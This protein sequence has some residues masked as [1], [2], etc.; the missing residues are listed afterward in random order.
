[1]IDYQY[2]Y[3]VG[4]GGIGMSAIARWFHAQSV[5]VVG[6]ELNASALT[7]QLMQE[8]IEIHYQ[9]C[10]DAIPTQIIHHKA[11]SLVIYTPAISADHRIL[12]YLK[13][14]HYTIYKRAAAL[15][16]ISRG[17]H[18]IA[19]AGTHGKT[20]TSAL[21]AH[22][23]YC[24]KKPMV[25][26]IGG[27]VKGYE[28]NILMHGPIT[29]DTIMVVE[30]D[31]FDRSF[32]Q[33][34]PN[35]AIVTS[36]DPDHLDTYTNAQ[37]FQEAFKTFMAQTSSAGKVIVHQHAAQQLGVHAPTSR[38]VN[39]ALTNTAIRA[40]RVHIRSGNFH[41]D[42][43]HHDIV[44]RDIRLAIP[45]YHQVEN[46]LA[47][48]TA[49]LELGIAPATIRQSIASFQGIQ[50][51]FDY[52]IR[53]EQLV[54]VDDY[55]HHPVEIT[56]VLQTLRTLYPHQHI[57]AIFRPHLYTRTRDWAHAFAKS[58]D[59]A[60]QV[61]LLDIYPARENPINNVTAK[62]IFDHMTLSQKWLCTPETLIQA[63]EKYGQ[64]TVWVLMGAGDAQRFV[65]MISRMLSSYTHS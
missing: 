64:S 18:T 62:S 16:M 19:V 55:A 4:I 23:L 14:Q 39:Y 52:I 37:E 45:G 7:D 35:T 10:V 17:F 57:A 27:I 47:V 36:V 5:K 31:E 28:T 43:T 8:G 22:I 42:Y 38:V 33:L 20:T 25:G 49:C 60:D 9:D 46:T 12:N 24:A 48:I 2:V 54:F 11:Q 6:Y 41:F 34:Y 21:L 40:E 56:A 26:F 53:N 3:L 1:M 13:Q 51:R 30:A 44:I 59:L 15:G 61:F 58:L 50:R 63:L 65:P 29:K 32:L